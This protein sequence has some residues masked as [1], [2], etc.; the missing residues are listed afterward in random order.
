MSEDAG[1][2]E[3]TSPFR[4]PGGQIWGPEASFVKEGSPPLGSCQPH[5]KTVH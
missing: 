5:V 3:G 1:P 2:R 4:D